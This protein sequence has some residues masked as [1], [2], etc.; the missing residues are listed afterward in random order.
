M[1]D[2]YCEIIFVG[3]STLDTDK[4]PQIK[5]PTPVNTPVVWQF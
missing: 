5:I 2:Q 3:I 4:A 1:W